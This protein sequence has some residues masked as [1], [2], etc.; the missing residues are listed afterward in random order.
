MNETVTS[1]IYK[2]VAVNRSETGAMNGLDMNRLGTWERK[3]LRTIYGV[4]EEQGVWRLRINQEL[5]VLYED[6]DIEADVKKKRL[7]WIGLYERIR[8]G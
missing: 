6:L 7:E 3:I 2:R 4:V 8:E 5:R 1:K